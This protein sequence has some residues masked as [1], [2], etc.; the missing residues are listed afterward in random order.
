[1]TQ[2]SFLAHGQLH[3]VL[4]DFLQTKDILDFRCIHSKCD[5][6][7]VLYA[8]TQLQD[9]VGQEV[10]HLPLY[11]ENGTV[12]FYLKR[13]MDSVLMM[14]LLRCGEDIALVLTQSTGAVR[15]IGRRLFT[16]KVQFKAFE[17]LGS[18]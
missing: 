2:L 18:C 15:F 17:F 13:T 8:K 6:Q 3:E 11:H 4:F 9:V 7:V 14:L 10:D 1:M 5:A 16:G 12:A